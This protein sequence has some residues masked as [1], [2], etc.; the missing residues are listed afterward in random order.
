MRF[1]VHTAHADQRKLLDA[2]GIDLVSNSSCS[3]NES[4]L[5]R[6]YSALGILPILQHAASLRRNARLGIC[7]SC[8]CPPNATH[9]QRA[10]FH[11]CQSSLHSSSSRDRYSMCPLSG[12]GIEADRTH[13]DTC[14]IADAIR[15]RRGNGVLSYLDGVLSV[16]TDVFL[17]MLTACLFPVR[18]H[19]PSLAA[20]WSDLLGAIR[21]NSSLPASM[22]ELFV[23]FTWY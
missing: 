6:T 13:S 3:E 18:L 16:S 14:Q 17:Q 4:Y 7:I 2:L 15:A 8:E 10:R 11:E 1:T 5:T 21:N 20:G 23:R 9:A 22:R 19:D 12:L